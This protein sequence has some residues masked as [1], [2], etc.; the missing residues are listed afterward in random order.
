L[1]GKLKR[2]S[3]FYFGLI[4]FLS[5]LSPLAIN[6]MS[7]EASYVNKGKEYFSH[8]RMDVISLLPLQPS[9]KV[10]E[11]GAGGGDTLMYI[12][13]KKLAGEVMGVE[14]L[15]IENSNQQNPLIDNFQIAD[16]EQENINA[17]E[18]YFDIIICADVLEH[19]ADPWKCIAR[20]SRHLK[21]GGR[22]IASIPNIREV[23]TLFNIVFRGDFKYEAKGGI[24]DN[25]HLRFFCKKN[26]LQLMSTDSLYPIYCKPN[27]L[28]KEVPQGK[29]RRFLNRLTFGL[30]LDFLAIQYLCVA[31]KR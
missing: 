20:I 15:K 23:K 3:V 31:E 10:L 24:L 1:P 25:T 13:E 7:N 8:I 21:K 16:I 18:D 27:I 26:M 6:F 17:P 30:I 14:L 28:L 29:K 4:P 11:I 5:S 9:Q 19:L 22:M 12:K 2:P